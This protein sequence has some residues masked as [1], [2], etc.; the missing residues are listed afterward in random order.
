MVD[1]KDVEIAVIHEWK[2]T[3]DRQLETH[4]SRLVEV[5]KCQQAILNARKVAIPFMTA[6]AAAML[7]VCLG[8][9]LLRDPVTAQAI[10]KSLIKQ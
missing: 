1:K 10:L 8:V 3:V 9:F 4:D 7:A 2:K 6:G 5:E